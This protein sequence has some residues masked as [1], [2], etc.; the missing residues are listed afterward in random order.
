MQPT[1]KFLRFVC[2]L[3]GSI[4][5]YA[6]TDAPVKTT[7]TALSWNQSIRGIHYLVGSERVDLAIPNGA[8]TSAFEC[9]ADQALTFYKDG[10]KDANGEPS[11]IPIATTT[12]A[13]NSPPPLLL[14]IEN[15]DQADRYKIAQIQLDLKSGGQDV[16]RIFN[17]SEYNLMTQFDEKRLALN[18][19]SNLTMTLPSI[20]GPNFGVMIALQLPSETSKE[21]KLAYNTFWPYRE[22]RSGLIF[23][24]DRPNR[25]GRIDVRR[26][27]VP[28]QAEPSTATKP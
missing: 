22:G 5:T 20:K 16:Y 28:T 3:A 6:Q 7:F 19:G 18:A 26:Y 24:S 27:Y 13:S 8:P 15:A 2:L 25:A 17:L 12:I 21:W 9:W 14:F 23:I 4:T 11:S 1:L 10:P